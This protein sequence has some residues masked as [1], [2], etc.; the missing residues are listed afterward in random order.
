[1]LSINNCGEM[2]IKNGEQSLTSGGRTILGGV[3]A[4]ETTS[5]DHHL[6]FVSIGRP[7]FQKSDHVHSNL[8]FHMPGTHDAARGTLSRRVHSRNRSCLV[9]TRSIRDKITC[10]W[11][12]KPRRS[13]YSC[14]P[15]RSAGFLYGCRWIASSLFVPTLSTSSPTLATYILPPFSTRSIS[16]YESMKNAYNERKKEI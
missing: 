13:R 6:V 3:S 16:R 10:E 12:S 5:V 2:H 9:G 1:M 8:N 15:G 14:S 7:R 4:R 11:V